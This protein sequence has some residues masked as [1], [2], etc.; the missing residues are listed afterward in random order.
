MSLTAVGRELT[1]QFRIGQLGIRSKMLTSLLQLWPLLDVRRLDA[2]APEW[3][4][5]STLTI[6]EHRRE[7]ARLA[8]RYYEQLRAVELPNVDPYRARWLDSVPDTAAHDA[9]RQSLI[10]TGPVTMKK[11]TRRI[12][13][14]AELD[15]PASAERSLE[16][17]Q[18]TA[19]IQVQGAAVRHTLNGGRE[20]LRQEGARDVR[21]L[22]FARVSDGDPC[23]FCAL[24][25][26][27]G[28]VYRTKDAAGRNANDRFTGPGLFK[29]HDK[30]ACTVMPVFDRDT[31]PGEQEA[32]YKALYEQAKKNAAVSREPVQ[33]EFRWLV[34]GHRPTN[35][36]K[37]SSSVQDTAAQRRRTVEL[38]IAALEPTF[39]S[40]TGRLAAGEAVQTPYEYQKDLLIRLRAELASL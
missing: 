31:P 25:I 36:R 27:R 3:L 17:V 24:M 10:V 14:L 4:R 2:T 26:S 9:I 19:L 28:F 8:A 15:S 12:T 7:S 35:R 39:A 32:K 13:N 38:Q 18:E 22:A 11:A 29:F 33:D 21:A 37:A 20:E 30:C 6:A 40:L 34:E 1:R 23:Y 16:K 5:L